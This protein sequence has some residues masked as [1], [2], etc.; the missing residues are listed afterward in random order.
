ML[1][2]DI[3]DRFPDFAPGDLLISLRTLH[4][5]AVLDPNSGHVK[6]WSRGPWRFQHDPDFTGDGKISVYNN[7]TGRSRSEII[8][9]DPS[10]REVSNELLDGELSFQAGGMG[11]HQYLPNGNVLIVVPQEGRIIEVSETGEVVFEFNNVVSEEFNG[12]VENGAWVPD[13]FFE[14]LPNCSDS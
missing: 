5:V 6:W 12:H 8:K 13:D 1:H 4:L 7:N 10:T 3:A 14:T 2:S 11:T 9:I